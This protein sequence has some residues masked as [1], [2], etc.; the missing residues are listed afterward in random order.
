MRADSAKAAAQT[1]RTP[2]RAVSFFTNESLRF[3]TL[4]AVST[5]AGIATGP[6]FAMDWISAN[7]CAVL[8]SGLV[9]AAMSSVGGLA[10]ACGP[11]NLRSHAPTSCR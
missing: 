4:A 6:V 9:K 10:Q 5:A 2:P 11:K 1:F 7:L 8:A 3:A